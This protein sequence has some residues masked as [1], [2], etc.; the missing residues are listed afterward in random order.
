MGGV[1]ENG[2]GTEH[3]HTWDGETANRK[4]TAERE[5]WEVVLP[6]TGGG[7]EGS[8]SHRCTNVNKQK[9]EHGRAVYF[10]ATASGPLQGGNA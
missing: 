2:E 7:H 10:Y 9:A 3:V 5:G 4:T 6:L 1:P 8:G